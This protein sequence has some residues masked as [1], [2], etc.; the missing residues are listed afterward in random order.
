MMYRY[1]VTTVQIPRGHHRA[2]R[3]PPGQRISRLIE[4]KV[5]ID[6]SNRCFI[7]T[8][9]I[10]EALKTIEEPVTPSAA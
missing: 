7:C 2:L 3:L 4:W 1:W 9:L 6:P 8:V 5:D 10:E